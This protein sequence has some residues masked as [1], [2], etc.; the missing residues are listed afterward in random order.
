MQPV[1]RKIHVCQFCDCNFTV[2]YIGIN[3]SK[4]VQTCTKCKSLVRQKASYCRKKN[5]F[6][7]IFN[8]VIILLKNNLSIQTVQDICSS[9]QISNNTYFKMLKHFNIKFDDLMAKAGRVR[10][11]ISKFQLSII[12]ILTFLLPDYEISIEK[13]FDDLTNPLTKS[14]LRFDIYIPALS[15][16]IECDGIQHKNQNHY[17]N[18]ITLSA[19]YTPSYKTDL[20]KE[21]YCK[22]HNISL[23]RIP[24]SRSPKKE[25]VL[26]MINKSFY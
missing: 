19:G 11:G 14:K 9:L 25:D 5:D 2:P 7:F 21:E 12:E 13:T 6:D 16:A 17:F 23:I 4:I 26:F 24:Y 22:K 20:I 8:A 18:N 10:K 3:S 15:L 1:E